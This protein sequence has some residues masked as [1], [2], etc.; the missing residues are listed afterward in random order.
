MPGNS[1]NYNNVTQNNNPVDVMDD[2]YK[3]FSSSTL[4]NSDGKTYDSVISVD[5]SSDLKLRTKYFINGYYLKNGGL[6]VSGL[7]QITSAKLFTLEAPK[8]VVIDLPNTYVDFAYN[9]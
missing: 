6:L 5:L 2:I 4:N 7:G 8:R 9:H 1:P 3:A